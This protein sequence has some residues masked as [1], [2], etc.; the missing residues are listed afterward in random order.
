MLLGSLAIVT[1]AATSAAAD[2]DRH[3]AMFG[4]RPVDGTLH[5]AGGEVRGIAQVGN[6]VVVGGSFT[7]VG[8]AK[9][10]AAGEVDLSSSNYL[11][12]FPEIDGVVHAAVSDGAG[13]WYLGGQFAAVGGTSRANLVQ[14]SAAGNV[15]VWDP[16]V[17]G[18]VYAL[19][20]TSDGDLIVGGDFS[21]IGGQ[22]ATRL[23]RVSSTT[24]TLEWTANVKG[25]TAG[26]AASVR[27]VTV[28]NGE[29]Y[30]GGDFTKV[31]TT[32]RNRLAA[33]DPATGALDPGFVSSPSGRVRALAVQGGTLWIAGDFT[34]VDGQQ[35]LRLARVDGSTG[36]LQAASLGFDRTVYD[37]ELDA[38]NG[39]LYTAG[40]FAKSG[41]ADGTLTTSQPR[42]A[43]I[44][45][46]ANALVPLSLG[47]GPT[48]TVYSLLLDGTG[49]LYIGGN[50]T[51]RPEKTQPAVLARI[52]LSTGTIF[53]VV[54]FYAVPRSLT[55]PAIDGG[56][57]R[58]LAAD[59][60]TG[61]L[62]AG[63]FS[64]YGT[65]NQAN[66]VSFDIATGAIDRNFLPD[67]NGPVYTV[68]ADA[69]GDGVYIGGE[70]STVGATTRHN[71]AKVSL[72]TGLADP[73]FQSDTNAY[74]KD[75]ALSPDGQRL[76]IGGAFDGMT[77]SGVTELVYK[78]AAIDPSTG[79]LVPGYAMPLT[80]PTN[81]QSEGSVRALALTPD[82]SRLMVIGNFSKVMG[83]DRPLIAQLDVSAA[84][85][86]VTDWRTSLY[87]QPCGR[88]EIGWMRDID[89]SPDGN[90]AFVVSAG[91]FYYPACDSANAFPMAVP[92]GGVDVTP[93]WTRMVGDTQESV[94][95]TGAGVFIG[96]HFRFLGKEQEV[97][98]RFQIGALDPKTGK[99]LSWNP[100]VSGFRGVLTIESE[101]AGLFVGGDGDTAGGV[102]HGGVALFAAMPPGIDV[103]VAMDR[104]LVQ[105]PGGTVKYS[106]TVTNTYPGKP[107]TITSLSDTLLGDLSTQ[108]GLP[109]TVASGGKFTC[110][111]A[112]DVTGTA[113]DVVTSTVT[114]SGVVNGQPV[115]DTDRSEVSVEAS[116]PG[117]RLRIGEAPWDLPYPGGDVQTNI[118]F[119]NLS[120]T[121]K[122]RVTKLTSPT[123]GVLTTA[124]GLPRTIGKDGLITCRLDVPLTGPIGTRPSASF[125]A[126]GKFKNGAK[127]SASGSI[128]IVIDPPVN[129]AP[130]SLIV[131]N[132]T[133]LTSNDLRLFDQL[134]TN[135]DVSVADDSTVMPADLV[136][137][138]AAVIA[139]SVVDTEL[140]TRLRNASTPILVGQNTVGDEMGLVASGSLPD[141][142]D[143]SGAAIRITD[144]LSDLAG[145]Q[146][147]TQDFFSSPKTVS[148][149]K[150]R[151]GAD[152]T[153]TFAPDQAVL[154][155]YNRTDAMVGGGTFP[156]CRTYLPLGSAAS[157]TDVAWKLFD[158]AVAH[159]MFDCGR[160]M[161]WTAIGNGTK[162]YGGDGQQASNVGLAAAW[163][164][165]IDASN[166][167]YVVDQDLNA[168]RRIGLGGTV[169]TVA[170]TGVAGATGDGGPATS[171]RLNA[172]TRVAVAA[173]GTLY[174]A[175]S[176]NN[177]VRRIATDGTISTVAGTGVAGY[178]GD[179][180]QAT[181]AR[182]KNPYDV[183]VAG[184]NLY[185]ADRDNARIR[186]V[187]L[188]SGIIT[189]VAGTGVSGFSGDDGPATSAR[190]ADPRSV[191]V[192][193]S[194]NLFIADTGNQ[195]VREV[196]VSGTITTVAGTGLTGNNGDGGPATEADLHVP[197]HVT[198]SPT[199]TLYI[200]ELNN[201]RVRRV[202]DGFIDTF[203][204]TGEFGFAGDAS[205]PI[206][207]KWDRPSA[208]AL[209]SAGNLWVV[210]R[211]NERV[212]VINAS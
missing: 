6:H 17:N 24:G 99:P 177:K 69:A 19:A 5:T 171:A 33:F 31:D 59:G 118:T 47:S 90:T 187:T 75:L 21:S 144:P 36:S 162:T 141:Q 212:R 196:D 191:A 173:D 23:A 154:M 26:A 79:A 52:Q 89:I 109:R 43:A 143:A 203:A 134:T 138:T 49:S 7:K 164:V 92:S 8:P 74:V 132:A 155:A 161:L 127:A 27:A 107:A 46:A 42:V 167:V 25:S 56:G 165:A 110:S 91:H 169:T 130:V 78:L 106:F 206:F 151:P 184:N 133:A 129:G 188:D 72:A 95:A 192:D 147:G 68:K 3:A 122:F 11:P 131:G 142:G 9:P 37:L 170:G 63:D 186:K 38:T 150:P 2:V 117:F 205:S 193:A 53:N 34:A 28:A 29:L 12:G 1:G 136:T 41:P 50:F 97:A 139:P 200:C 208:S 113:P 163:G 119:M 87:D 61:L 96:G 180:G 120:Y 55:S 197:V 73:A 185:I 54:P 137:S 116:T 48:G 4:E 125:T 159:T 157:F 156:A 76:Y 15:T 112:A 81:T 102:P 57:I 40:A 44:D 93:R 84:A 128:D 105:Q 123:Y 100:N 199:G 104:L 189:T 152:L 70:F 183:A 88:G 176:G 86:V 121:K 145:N 210:D 201:D 174:I 10:G 103:R 39:V 190:I 172:P 140:A 181:Q 108:C 179:G 83:A 82:G 175:D 66:L 182:L 80:E 160:G 30:V 146:V 126:N 114:A 204:G 148:W 115:S 71:L 124:C 195:R 209:D 77:S 62:T 158:R 153:A 60:P 14:V 98:Q 202:K 168:V 211:N 16:S 45:T 22:P 58:V 198:V 178:S 111:K 166:N 135:F 94:A 101:P 85:P 67:V 149:L 194:G 64:D 51:L 35:R 65:I 207:S 18:P 13:G 20:R 32:T